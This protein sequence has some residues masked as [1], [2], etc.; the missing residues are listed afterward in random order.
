MLG[1]FLW[2]ATEMMTPALKFGLKH[3]LRTRDG[4]FCH[5]CGDPFELHNL[6][7]DHVKPRCRGGSNEPS[8]LVLACRM[9]NEAKG[10]MTVQTFYSRIRRM[11]V[12]SLRQQTPIQL[13][14]AA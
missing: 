9:C 1:C 2:V 4:D 8:N 5:Y 3:A 7:I 13:R 10:E 6:T 11:Y 14:E 12:A